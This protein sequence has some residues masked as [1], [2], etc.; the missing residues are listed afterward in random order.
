MEKNEQKNHAIMIPY[1]LQGHVIPFVHLAMKLASKGFTIT[2][3]NTESIHHQITKS[4]HST[5]SPTSDAGDDIFAEARKSGIDI[6][7]SI[8]NDGFPLGFDRSLNHDQFFE[9][10]LHVMSAHIDELV[11]NT[12][13]Q[14]PPPTC[15]IADTF[16]VW[17][18]MISNK[19][20][21]VNVS[22]WTEPALVFTL[23]YHLD[24][25][26][27]N[28]H[29]ACI[30]NRDDIIDYIPGVRAIEPKDMMSY[31][32]A[33]DISTVVHRII[34][35]AFQDVKK[36]D[37]IICNTVEEL[38]H[39]TISALQEKQPTY[40]I[41]PIFPTG[42]TKSVVATS[43]WSESDC[44][45][46]LD[47]KPHGS[48]LYV[49][50][51]SY[52]HVSKIEIMEIAN[53]LLLSGK[54]IKRDEVAEKISRVIGGKSNDDDELRKNIMEVKRKV[55]NA[56]STVGSS[57]KNLNQFITDMGMKSK[58]KRSVANHIC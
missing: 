7:Y 11:A 52:A 4:S 24:L 30:E 27:A 39:E 28:G 51:G 46:W 34:F 50:F 44:T 57:E 41:G 16:F 40:A 8:V 45:Q 25:L 19:Y 2:F 56:L 18:S 35:K 6:R 55:E 21:L 26:K 31:L 32:Q 33:S 49:S 43:L 13:K 23:Y 12:F 38:E 37:F 5:T 14:S 20:N 29:F 47:T 1:P 15:L 42:F 3:V 48:V 9:G 58:K 17:S 10:V 53:G 54:K 36:A 22:F